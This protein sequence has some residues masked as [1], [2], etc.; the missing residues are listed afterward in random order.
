MIVNNKP[1]ILEMID[2]VIR[3]E[4]FKTKTTKNGAEFLDKIDTFKPDLVTLD[5]MMPGLNTHQILEELKNKNSNLK[6]ILLT[7]VRLST[8]GLQQLY[9]YDN[10]AEYVSKPF[11]INE[12]IN[13]IHHHSK[14]KNLE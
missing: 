9:N 11:E 10:I 1:D 13:K 12:L 8:H 14:K 7:A 4:G 6:I 5:Y 3:K 2:L